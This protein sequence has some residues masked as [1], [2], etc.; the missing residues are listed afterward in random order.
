MDGELSSKLEDGLVLGR[1]L[2]TMFRLH[3]EI[4]LTD[5]ICSTF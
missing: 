1:L 5:V 4:A 3:S 2:N